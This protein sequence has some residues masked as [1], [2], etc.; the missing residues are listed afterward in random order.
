MWC[1]AR[2]EM[3]RELWLDKDLVGGGRKQTY[4]TVPPSSE[5]A[6]ENHE[7]SNVRTP[8]NRN[9]FHC[10][11]Y[12]VLQDE[13][14]RRGRYML[15]IRHVQSL[16]NGNTSEAKIPFSITIPVVII[17][18]LRQ[19]VTVYYNPPSSIGVEQNILPIW[20]VTS[21][22]ATLCHTATKRH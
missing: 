11:Y 14:L 2:R 22:K 19:Q 10:R 15:H 7:T 21:F 4:G 5:E 13:E 6:E 3:E 20:S 12:S 17:N 8:R 9:E 18:T 1:T 16:S